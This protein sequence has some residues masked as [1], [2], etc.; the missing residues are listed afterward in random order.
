MDQVLFNDAVNRIKGEVFNELNLID[1]L[2]LVQRTMYEDIVNGRVRE[3]KDKNENLRIK[4]EEESKRMNERR[5]AEKE[6]LEEICKKLEE[7]AKQLEQASYENEKEV[8]SLMKDA[9]DM[10]RNIENIPIKDCTTELADAIKQ[11]YQ[12]MLDD[13]W[14]DVPDEYH[15]RFFL[16]V[17][18]IKIGVVLNNDPDAKLRDLDPKSL[19]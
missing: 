1:C 18:K 5:Q 12:L 6:K 2:P 3:L 16:A 15:L 4:Q 9:D 17:A 11:G 13:K 19:W 14:A 7:G 10:L 8:E